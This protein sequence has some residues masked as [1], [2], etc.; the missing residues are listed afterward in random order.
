MEVS[1]DSFGEISSSTASRPVCWKGVISRGDRRT[2][3][4][5]ELAWQRGARL[6]GWDEMLKP[7]RWCKLWADCN[8]D[9]ERQLHEPYDVH[10]QTALGPRHVKYGRDYLVKE[11]IVRSCN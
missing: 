3:D 4:A 5:I 7:E 2:C 1:H 8:I 6:D 9:V 11:Q 10:G